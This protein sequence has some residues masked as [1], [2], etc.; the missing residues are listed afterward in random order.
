MISCI[1][2][3]FWFYR[4]LIKVSFWAVC[5]GHVV[6]TTIIGTLKLRNMTG[7]ILA[8]REELVTS[9]KWCGSRVQNWALVLHLTSAVRK[10]TS[11]RVTPPQETSL[12]DFPKMLCDYGLEQEALARVE[13]DQEGLEM[14][15]M[16]MVE[17]ET[18]ALEQME[19]PL[20]VS[21]S[22]IHLMYRSDSL[23]ISL[24]SIRR[25]QESLRT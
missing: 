11:W 23:N 3:E 16:E 17:M 18:E 4:E 2:C 10:P 25:T 13:L 6:D 15:E 14:G 8:T 9:H 7:K 19:M 5:H 1:L 24:R 20:Q 22:Y 21:I 12:A